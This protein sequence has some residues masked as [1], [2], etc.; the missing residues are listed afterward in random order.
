MPSLFPGMNPYLEGEEW[1]S[2]SA[3]FCGEIARQLRPKLHPLYVALVVR[4]TINA[5]SLSLPEPAPQFSIEIQDVKQ[6]KLV[7]LIEILSPANKR[8]EGY[9]EYIWAITLDLPLPVVPV[10][11]LPGDVDVTLDYTKPPEITLEEEAATWA[12]S[13][14]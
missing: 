14:L 13:I 8:G 12:T 11:L 5:T 9:Q 7:T 2:F 10:P 6:R 3:E 4:R 1:T